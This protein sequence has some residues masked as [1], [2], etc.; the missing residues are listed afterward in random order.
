MVNRIATNFANPVFFYNRG[1][2]LW[3]YADKS[4][5]YYF[6]L[7]VQSEDEAKKVIEKVIDVQ[8][9]GVPDWEQYLRY[10]K[11]KRDYTTAG[12]VAVMGETIRKPRKRPSAKVEFA[13]A[14]LFIPGTT[15]P[16]VLVDRTGKKH[17]ALRYV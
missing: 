4:K 17:N 3:S 2:E 12:T 7:T 11:D 13:Y 1:K 10:H 16:I 9:S 5:G 8:N 15:K 14:E 6:Q